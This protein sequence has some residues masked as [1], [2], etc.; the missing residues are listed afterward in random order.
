MNSDQLIQELDML[1]KS[2]CNPEI[3]DSKEEEIPLC[4]QYECINSGECLLFDINC[5]HLSQ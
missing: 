4:G 5:K 1:I 2:A 3:I